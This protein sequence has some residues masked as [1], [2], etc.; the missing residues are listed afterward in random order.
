MTGRFA[1]AP[2]S[3]FTRAS[4]LVAGVVAGAVVA[5]LGL[6]VD[7]QWLAL[8]GLLVAVV[9]AGVLAASLLVTEQER[10]ERI[11]AEIKRLS[12][13]HARL[14]D[15]RRLISASILSSRSCSVTRSE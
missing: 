2:T 13:E 9:A 8:I 6:A 4:L 14:S 7:V 5:V 10:D 12:A 15:Q 11:E 1:R 3:T